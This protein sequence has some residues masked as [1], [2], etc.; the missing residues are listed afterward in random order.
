MWK[1]IL[2]GSIGRLLAVLLLLT[3]IVGGVGAWYVRSVSNELSALSS[4]NLRASVHLSGAER[5]LWELRFALP[6][7]LMGDA[8]TRRQVAAAA[9][10][11]LKAIDEH[12]ASFETLPLSVEE[13]RILE[14]W[15]NAFGAY[16]KARPHYFELVDEGKLDE[17]KEYRAQS[18]NPPAAKS[19]ET[20]RR[21]IEAQQRIGTT[22]EE[23]ARASA[24]TA[25]VVTLG[26]VLLALAIGAIM[27]R[28]LTR[29]TSD[30]LVSLQR[31][32]MALEET[33]VGLLSNARELSTS[34]TEVSTTL[35][36]LLTTSRQIAESSRGVA[37]I[38]T[39]TGATARSGDE[40]TKR[41]QESLAIMRAK[42][43]EIVKRMGALDR[44][45]QEIGG[46]VD[47]INE[48]SEQ[49]NILSINATIEAVSA[50]QAGL[51][52]GTVAN[53]IRQ[54]ANRVGTSARGIRELTSAVRDAT[55]MTARATDDG[56]K[57]VVTSAREFGGVIETFQQINGRVNATTAATREIEASTRQ[58]ATAVAQVNVAMTELA[59]A[60]KDTERSS[61][62]MTQTCAELRLIADR[63]A[64]LTGAS[65]EM[66][67]VR[68]NNGGSGM[69]RPS[70]EVQ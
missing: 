64:E 36:E 47:L 51:R 7:Y 40:V 8:D 29:E 26:L 12:M 6:N 14:E 44:S 19:V 34:A 46:I 9:P 5:A 28:S 27:S 1:S 43:E 66:R 31:S 35:H 38:A 3:A 18:T 68:G 69:D 15:Q 59:R 13:R 21:L 37:T 32:S 25:S 23:H 16:K 2:G 50:G 20:L 53:E 33:A 11:H 58:Q 17:A 60:A 42:V 24:T 57:A 30:V 65:N 41:A 52:F 62:N 61:Q 45:S 22:R 49:T 10:D 55:T 67:A 63:L 4:E 39:E 56:E 54:L 70:L 48:L